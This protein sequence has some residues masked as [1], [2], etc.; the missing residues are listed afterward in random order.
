MKKSEINYDRL[1]RI[2]LAIFWATFAAVIFTLLLVSFLISMLFINYKA[3]SDSITKKE[4]QTVILPY[5]PIQQTT[6]I[7]TVYLTNYYVGDGDGSDDTTISNLT[8]KDFEVGKNGW[9]YYQNNVVLACAMDRANRKLTHNDFR[10][11]EP[12][13]IVTF[14]YL[15]DK[16]D[17]IC[18]DTGI[19]L[20]GWNNEDIQRL[21]I[22]IS[23][24]E[25]AFGKVVSSV[26]E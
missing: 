9:Y 5:N 20:H 3:E 24:K 23:S 7:R 25:Y 21:D 6:T 8:N 18:L 2:N 16:Y 26:H 10:Y 15:G 12:N 13:E 17:G 1:R 22:R 19:A 4:V 11:W 14:E